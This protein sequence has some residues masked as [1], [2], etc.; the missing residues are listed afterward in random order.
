MFDLGKSL[1]ANKPN[2]IDTTDGPTGCALLYQSEDCASLVREMFQFE[3]WNEPKC[4]K[5][6]AVSSTFY[7]EQSGNIVILELNQSTD[8]VADAQEFASHLPTHKGIIVIGQEDSISTLRKL[9]DMGFYYLFWPI[10]KHEFADFVI[11]VHRNLQ[12]YSGVSK[13]RKAKRVAVVGSKGGIGTSLISTELSSKLSSQEIDTILVDHQ[14][15]DSNIDVLL[16]LEEFRSRA[17]DEYSV[18]IHEL[19]TDG[20]I[21]YLTKIRKNLR[22]LAL[23][24]DRSQ[25]DI[26]SYNLTLCELLSRNTNFIVEDF[27]GSVDFKVDPHM[28]IENFDV[29]VVVFE[30]SVSSVRNAKAFITQL[31]N[32]QISMSKRVRMITL[33]N[34]HRPESTFVIDQGDLQKYLGSEVNLN[35]PYCRSLSHL[36]IEGKRAHKHDKSVNTTIEELT[37]LI[38]GQT[39]NRSTSWF[40][41]MGAG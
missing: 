37:R 19:D 8:I 27:S 3:G 11:N 7:S 24:G 22:L 21:S 39:T 36:I 29:V 16:A 34:H 15:N 30:P 18:P 10:N 9:K 32:K 40:A 4:I 14:Y 33:A 13:Q 25:E 23:R 26:L 2:L 20:A 28:L 17:I 35:M 31:E 38:N 41:R 1:K 5:Q 6:S 12:T